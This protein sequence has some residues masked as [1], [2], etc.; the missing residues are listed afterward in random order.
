[1][2]ERFDQIRTQNWHSTDCSPIFAVILKW[3]YLTEV[4]RLETCGFVDFFSRVPSTLAT[5]NTSG[6]QLRLWKARWLAFRRKK[7]VPGRILLLQSWQA[8][9][10]SRIRTLQCCCIS[11][12]K[13][14]SLNF[15]EPV[16][17]LHG[18]LEFLS[19]SNNNLLLTKEPCHSPT[20]FLSSWWWQ[21]HSSNR[22]SRTRLQIKS[23][24]C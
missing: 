7:G 24:L 15:R 14:T 6:W 20:A 23:C 5:K 8:L 1:M 4:E 9:F 11:S 17:K 21:T 16:E 12:E 18:S 13:A 22:I 3:S 10:Q 2:R 19:D